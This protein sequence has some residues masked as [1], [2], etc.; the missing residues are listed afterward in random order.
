MPAPGVCFWRVLYRG[1]ESSRL[2]RRLAKKYRAQ[3]HARGS[4]AARKSLRRALFARAAVRLRNY[5]GY[6]SLQAW[7]A[8]W[9]VARSVDSTGQVRRRAPRS[10]GKLRVGILGMIAYLPFFPRRLFCGL[11]PE[12]EVHLFETVRE[13]PLDHY[14]RHTEAASLHNLVLSWN[15]D[16]PSDGI[17]S[18]PDYAARVEELARQINALELDLLLVSEP[19][20]EIYDVLDR[21]DV[22]AV[23][24][25]TATSNACFHPNID[26]QFYIHSIKDYVVRGNRLFCQAS[27]QF[28]TRPEFVVPYCLFFDATGY[29]GTPVPWAERRHVL[30]FH[31][32]LVKASQPAFLKML[33][34]L[35]EE[36]SELALVLYG[37]DSHKALQTIQAAA[38]RRGVEGRVDYR[39]QFSLTRNSAGEIVDPDWHRFRDELRQAKLAP[40]SFPMASGC[41]RFET[42]AAGVPCVNLALRT[43]NRRWTAPDETLVDIPAL[44]TPSATATTLRDYKQIA[45]RLL[46]EQPLAE[47]VIAEQLEIVARL[48]STEN[49]WRQIFD[50]HQFWRQQPTRTSS[51]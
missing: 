24:D 41:A 46:H 26:I 2:H 3:E 20:R 33:L 36:D 30:F 43:D 48:G 22:P 37:M 11:P 25:L 40:T 32:R 17:A 23:A 10:T 35:L 12:L 19:G 44:Y 5:Q 6:V 27:A 7:R 15:N 8:F 16:L 13:L 50:A 28:L 47:Q 9:S 34:D 38:R 14:L 29:E 31:G 42:Y 39:G 51:T 49:F 21:V 18:Q 1:L 4:G 45:L